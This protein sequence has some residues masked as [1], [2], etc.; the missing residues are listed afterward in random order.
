MCLCFTLHKRVT[1]TM[2]SSCQAVGGQRAASTVTSVD[3]VC[4]GRT[5]ADQEPR[6]DEMRHVRHVAGRHMQLLTTRVTSAACTDL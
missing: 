3:V 6:E 4:G 2:L 1:F 5:C